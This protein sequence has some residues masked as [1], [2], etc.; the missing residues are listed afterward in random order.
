MRGPGNSMN[1]Q[2]CTP[3]LGSQHL[4]IRGSEQ[5]GWRASKVG[6]PL[7]LP[8]GRVVTSLGPE[9]RDVPTQMVPHKKPRMQ[10][11]VFHGGML[12]FSLEVLSL[13]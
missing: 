7:R 1:P 12:V 4:G 13:C 10:G 9:P 11:A 5:E 8:R 3:G 2:S 6:A